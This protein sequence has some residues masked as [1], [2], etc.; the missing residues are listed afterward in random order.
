MRREEKRQNGAHGY[1]ASYMAWSLKRQGSL[2]SEGNNRKSNDLLLLEGRLLEDWAER[3]HDG[4]HDRG[5]VLGEDAGGADSRRGRGPLV[6]LL[7]RRAERRQGRRDLAQGISAK[8]GLQRAHKVG[9]LA[10][11]A[12]GDATELARAFEAGAAVVG[13]AQDGLEG[14]GELLASLERDVASELAGRE[15]RLEA[16]DEPVQALEAGAD[17]RDARALLAGREAAAAGAEPTSLEAVAAGL[18]VKAVGAELLDDRGHDALEDRAEVLR[19]EAAGADRRGSGRPLEELLEGRGETRQGRRDSAEGAS[20][21]AGLQRAH[22]VGELDQGARGDAAELTDV[23]ASG[24]VG[25]LAQD[26]L[27]GLGKLLASLEREVP[28]ELAGRELGLEAADEPIQALEAGADRRDARALLA[29]RKAAAAGAE[30]TETS[31]LVSPSLEAVGIRAVGTHSIVA[32]A[33]KVTEAGR[34]AKAW[35]NITAER[36]SIAETAIVN[37]ARVVA[38]DRVAGVGAAHAIAPWGGGRLR[39]VAPIS[40]GGVLRVLGEATRSVSGGG[41]KGS[42]GQKASNVNSGQHGGGCGGFCWLKGKTGGGKEFRC[43]RC[44][45]QSGRW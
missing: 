36:E 23:E 45:V 6:E 15:L 28:S 37:G 29:G 12:R 34:S 26:G 18:L 19:D 4:L 43:G 9:E 35:V 5:E 3:G 33:L 32:A 17:G 24:T 39:G 30:T 7:E 25:G 11:G 40:T 2:P 38:V 27:E 44:Y 42:G 21:K 10:K 20:I 16:A 13:L 22:K 1:M 31:S 41:S 14:P 8:A